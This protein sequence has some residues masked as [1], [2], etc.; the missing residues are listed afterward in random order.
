MWIDVTFSVGV[1]R[2]NQPDAREH[3]D[4]KTEQLRQWK[5]SGEMVLFLDVCVCVCRNA[6]ILSPSSYVNFHS[7]IKQ[8]VCCMSWTK[9]PTLSLSPIR[10]PTFWRAKFDHARSKLWKTTLA[11]ACEIVRSSLITCALY[12]MSHYW[13]TSTDAMDIVSRNSG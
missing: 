5:F 12:I 10:S 4:H 13:T 8:I 6:H 1:G 7:K 2:K 11:A 9:H 3:S